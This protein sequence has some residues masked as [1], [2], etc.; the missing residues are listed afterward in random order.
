MC[1]VHA[2]EVGVPEVV[3]LLVHP[4]KERGRSGE[5]L[6]KSADRVVLLARENEVLQRYSEALGRPGISLAMLLIELGRW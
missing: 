3:V 2:E 6:C 5:Q 4:N 1:A